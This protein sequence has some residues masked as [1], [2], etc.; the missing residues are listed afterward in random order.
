MDTALIIGIA[1]ALLLAAGV[2]VVMEYHHFG[3]RQKVGSQL[4]KHQTE[5]AAVRK[6]LVGYTKYAEYLPQAKVHLADNAKGLQAKIQREFTYV[7]SF[8]REAKSS[9][10]PVSIIQRYL[11]EANFAFDLRPG[12][13]ELV[14]APGGLE[15]QLHGKPTLQGIAN[16]RPV[17][18]EVTN[19]GVLENEPVTVKQIQ[20]KLIGIAQKHG[21]A[22]ALEDATCALCERKLAETLRAL[23][24]TQAGVRQVPAIT[25]V[26]K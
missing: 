20:Q 21:E 25:F 10:P 8:N 26:Y 7:E 16:A 9:K 24:L 12:S 3:E 2:Y 5:A 1:S 11:V 22:M 23:L 18:H 13:F 14:G 17:A 4:L 19:E 6:E 15:V